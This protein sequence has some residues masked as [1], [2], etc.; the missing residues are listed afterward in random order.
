L[1]GEGQGEGEERYGDHSPSPQS[2]PSEGRGRLRI[3]TIIGG[4]EEDFQLERRLITIK[5]HLMFSMS[6]EEVSCYA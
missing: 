1:R 4:T 2:S 6:G 5:R 3:V